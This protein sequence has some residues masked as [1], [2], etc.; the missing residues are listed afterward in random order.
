M[1]FLVPAAVGLSLSGVMAA[2]IVT[3]SA[4]EHSYFHITSPLLLLKIEG[5][6]APYLAG[7]IGLAVS[8][9][10]VLVRVLTERA[11]WR[12]GPRHSAEMQRYSH[13]L[14][15]LM[16]K[17]LSSLNLMMGQV[18]AGDSPPA[19]LAAMQEETRR[20]EGL[21]K[22]IRDV[23][24]IENAP[25][26]PAEYRLDE[27]VARQVASINRVLG[28]KRITASAPLIPPPP[29]WGDGDLVAIGLQCILDN[30]VKYTQPEGLILVQVTT[31]RGKALVTI[32]DE[33]RG[34][35]ALDLPLV[36]ERLK[37]GANAR[38]IAGNGVGLSLA[39]IIVE[40]HGGSLTIA[41]VEG[42]GTEVTIRLPLSREPHGWRVIAGST[43]RRMV[44]A[45]LP[46]SGRG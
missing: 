46:R 45:L 14:D 7:A 6:I 23:V 3:S 35:P 36:A 42:K 12:T 11:G 13:N 26:V 16:T 1:P 24:S 33:G 28:G 41:S 9:A 43:I 39:K 30:A 19:E 44:G 17:P 2:A 21:L 38:D 29:I 10:L 34:I 37:R 18:A 5:P 27:V 40:K 31:E 20:L 4:P 32:R 15:E 25:L 8:A 22:S